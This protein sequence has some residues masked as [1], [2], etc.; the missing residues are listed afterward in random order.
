M[1]QKAELKDAITGNVIYPVT[2]TECILDLGTL[3]S[4]IS[5]LKQKVATLETELAKKLD[6]DKLQTMTQAEYDSAAKD[7]DTYYFIKEEA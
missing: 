4:E 7:S 1:A 2:R 5:E 3:L 6:A